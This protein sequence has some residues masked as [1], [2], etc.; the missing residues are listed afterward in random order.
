MSTLSAELSEEMEPVQEGQPPKRRDLSRRSGLFFFKGA[1]ED[2][3][4]LDYEVWNG[5]RPRWM[6]VNRASGV[7]RRA[8]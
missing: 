4:C 8:F 3:I 6:D 2:V 5:T 7:D 1:G